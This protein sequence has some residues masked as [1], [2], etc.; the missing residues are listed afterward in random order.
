ML[1]RNAKRG[2]TNVAATRAQARR[3]QESPAARIVEIESLALHVANLVRHHTH[4]D[5]VAAVARRGSAIGVRES[6]TPRIDRATTG[7]NGLNRTKRQND[8][9]K[10]SRHGRVPS[11][12]L[13]RQSRSKS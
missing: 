4:Q 3:P 9:R 8:A 13:N 2:P 1:D 6:S 12:L 7:T 10:P 11:A 5:A